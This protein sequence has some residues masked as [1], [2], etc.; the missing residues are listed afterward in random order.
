MLIYTPALDVHNCVYRFLLL[1]ENID[2]DSVRWDSL[3]IADYYL[4]YPHLILN[5]KP[6]PRELGKYKKSLKNIHNPYPGKADLKMMFYALGPIHKA[7]TSCLMAKGIL[8]I[9]AFGAMLI[10]RTD[11]ELPSKLSERIRD[12]AV[13]SESWFRAIVEVVVKLETS[14][15]A[16]LK[17]RSGLMEYRYDDN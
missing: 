7:V 1:L 17:N 2:M 15:P 8:S 16:G 11:V 12:D 4:L 6:L 14:G 9:D 3:R 10:E 13:T 5:I